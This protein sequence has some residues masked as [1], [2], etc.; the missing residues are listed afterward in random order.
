MFYMF[1]KNLT[2]LQSVYFKLTFYVEQTNRSGQ[3]SKN[4]ATGSGIINCISVSF[5]K[6]WI[7]INSR[8]NNAYIMLLGTELCHNFQLCKDLHVKQ[9]TPNMP[10]QLSQQR[11]ILLYLFYLPKTYDNQLLVTV[12][13]V[14][15]TGHYCECIPT[16]TGRSNSKRHLPHTLYTVPR[17]LNSRGIV[18]HRST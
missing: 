2:H 1:P 16:A 14:I 9:S 3:L 5:S 17:S 12:V 11:D 10:F 15:L 6:A 8:K 4:N 7:P 18:V 13:G